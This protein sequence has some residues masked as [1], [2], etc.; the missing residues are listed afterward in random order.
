MYLTPALIAYL[1]LVFSERFWL[2]VF[3]SSFGTVP[4]VKATCCRARFASFALA[5]SA[6]FFAIMVVRHRSA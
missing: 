4:D 6:G 3:R 2:G 1:R 5:T